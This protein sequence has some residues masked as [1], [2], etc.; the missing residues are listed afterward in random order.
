MTNFVTGANKVDAH[1]LN[2]NPNRDFRAGATVDI[3]NASPGEA[4]PFA[5]AV[6]FNLQAW[7]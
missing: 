1:F 4:A 5:T 2:V 7:K 6:W 3:K